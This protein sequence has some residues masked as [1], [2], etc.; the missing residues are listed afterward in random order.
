MTASPQPYAFD[1]FESQTD[2]G[3]VHHPGSCAY[4]P[5]QQVY[6]LTGA[7]ANI[8]GDHDDFHFV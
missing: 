3:S 4:D 2:I 8:W 5:E 7:G 1:Q 6:T